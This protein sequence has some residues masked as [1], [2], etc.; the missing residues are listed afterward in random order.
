MSHPVLGPQDQGS[1]MKSRHE[2]AEFLKIIGVCGSWA[3][4]KGWGRQASLVWPRVGSGV[5]YL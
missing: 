5:V 3:I 2:P 4:R 1:H